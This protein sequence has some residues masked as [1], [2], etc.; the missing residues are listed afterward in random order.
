MPGLTIAPEL[1]YTGAF[2]DFLIDNNGFSTD[3]GTSQQGLL[4]NLTVTYDVAPNM[5][6]Y[7][8]ARNLFYS[9][10]EPVNGYQTPGPAAVVGVRMRL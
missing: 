2:K 8:A 7:A 10:F 3:V 6:L 1:L 4:V 5:Q 9:R